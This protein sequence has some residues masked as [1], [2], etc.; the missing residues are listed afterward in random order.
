MPAIVHRFA[1]GHRIRLAVAGGSANY[2]GGLLPSV[3][4][5]S[6]GSSAQRLRLPVPGAEPPAST[7]VSTPPRVR[8]AL[9]LSRQAVRPGR[10]LRVTATGLAAGR[11]FV[12][13]LGGRTLAEGRTTK[14]GAV[15]RAVTVPRRT[16]PGLRRVRL[17]LRGAPGRHRVV[18]TAIVRVRR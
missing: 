16:K 11:R 2:R 15:R 9:R 8:P 10:R 18:L 3:V 17:V 12:L 4:R 1:P 14:S 6:T 7:G 5:I 13:R